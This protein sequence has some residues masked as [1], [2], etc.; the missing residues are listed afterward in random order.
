M[1]LIA[2]S[3]PEKE[4]TSIGFNILYNFHDDHANML[5]IMY[6]RLKLTLNLVDIVEN[7]E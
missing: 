3:R 2:T 7:R 6:S 4:V 1:A 5:S